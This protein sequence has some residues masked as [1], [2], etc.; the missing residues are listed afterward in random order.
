MR[1]HEPHTT[2]RARHAASPNAATSRPG[3]YLKPSIVQGDCHSWASR[4]NCRDG[5]TVSA[6][7]T[8]VSQSRGRLRRRRV[9][10]R[11]EWS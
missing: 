4:T 2:S 10:G 1:T 8:T 6:L 7:T 9:P 11:R 3:W 5:D